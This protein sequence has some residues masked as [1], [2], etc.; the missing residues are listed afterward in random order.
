[1]VETR[2]PQTGAIVDGREPAPPRTSRRATRFA[3][4]DADCAA[5]R[6]EPGTSTACVVMAHGLGAIKEVGLDRFARRFSAAGHDVVAFD[7]RGFGESTG[8][9]PQVVDIAAQQQDWRAAIA[10][11]RGLPASSGSCCGAP[12]IAAATCSPS[13]PSWTGSPE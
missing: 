10:F 2:N 3:S 7:Y 12:P 11:S 13:R 4:G 5:W 8:G 6:Y 9:P 1:M